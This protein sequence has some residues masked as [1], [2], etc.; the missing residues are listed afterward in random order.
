MRVICA[1][2]AASV[3]AATPAS[4]AN[5]PCSKKKGGVVGCLGSK[6]LCRDGSTSASKKTC[7]RDDAETEQDQGDTKDE[8]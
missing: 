3:I 8:D 1:F 2:I 5:T 6:F 4:A 7:S